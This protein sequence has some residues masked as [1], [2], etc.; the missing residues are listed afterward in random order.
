M[1]TNVKQ[2]RIILVG[3][4]ARSGKSAF[5]LT[6]AR[7]LGSARLFLATAQAGDD[8]MHARIRRHR[9]TRGADFQT[10]E[11]PLAVTDVLRRAEGL[12][13]VVL[14][15][16]TL[17][18]ANLLVGGQDADE[19]LR[20]VEELAGVLDQR[21][22]QAVIVTSEVGLGLVPETPLGRTFRDVA[23]LAHQRLAGLADEVYLGVLGLMLRLK[24][25]PV[26]PVVGGTAL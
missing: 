9:E 8:E 15:C 22:T 4:G 21:R 26:A 25:A 7:R 14:D 20:Q 5:A 24:P 11:E 23:G 17:W 10:V 3:G 1:E 13:V 19:V 6:V 2:R 12:D 18:L 16:L